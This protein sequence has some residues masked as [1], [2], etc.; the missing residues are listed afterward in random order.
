MLFYS[1]EHGRLGVYE[2]QKMGIDPNNLPDNWCRLEI[3]KESYDPL[4]HSLP[5]KGITQ[6]I[7][8]VMTACF[9]AKPLPYEVAAKNIRAKRD[10]LFE[11]SFIREA[12]EKNAMLGEAIPSSVLNYCQAL[13]DMPEQ[14]GF[15]YYVDWPVKP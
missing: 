2:L 10:K 12:V 1:E 5:D 4:T 14:E 6:E 8:G 11:Q 3:Y 7:D 15:P 9:Y 13:R